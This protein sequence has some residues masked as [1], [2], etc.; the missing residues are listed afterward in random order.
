L[1]IALLVLSSP[2]VWP[3]KRRRLP[4]SR[5]HTR[6]KS[7]NL[8]VCTIYLLCMYQ[9]YSGIKWPPYLAACLL[10]CT[11]FP[12]WF[13]GR[14][15][16]LHVTYVALCTLYFHL[17]TRFVAPPYMCMLSMLPKNLIGDEP[18]NLCFSIVKKL[19]LKDKA[20]T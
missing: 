16:I 8:C 13:Y 4:R 3:R 10:S 6:S 20:E 18:C 1:L 15:P 9:A 7:L 19:L 17:L 2:S 11:S 5:L 12:R 14:L